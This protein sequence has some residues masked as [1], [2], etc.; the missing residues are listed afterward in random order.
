MSEVVVKAESRDKVA[1]LSCVAMRNQGW[2]PVNFYGYKIENRTYVVQENELL[3]AIRS[4]SKVI[5]LETAEGKKDVVVKEVQ[6]HPVTWNLLHADFYA[7]AA[8]KEITIKVPLRFTGTSYGVKNMG[9]VLI[10]SSRSVDIS[11]LPQYIPNEIV[12]DVTPMK[13]R[14]TVHAKDLQLENIK[15]ASRGDQLLCRVGA[16]RASLSEAGGDK[17]GAAAKGKKK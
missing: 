16:T 10:L 6:R 8:E 3:K 15:I 14:D 13:I 1:G 17:G 4:G 7:L 12:V 2:I 9:G 11:C 5:T